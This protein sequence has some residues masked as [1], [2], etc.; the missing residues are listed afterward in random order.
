V[1]LKLLLNDV[2]LVATLEV[3]TSPSN[4]STFIQVDQLLCTTSLPQIAT[5][6]S[7]T[8]LASNDVVG[9]EDR[10]DLI[11]LCGSV[12]DKT[13]RGETK[14]LQCTA[15]IHHELVGTVTASSIVSVNVSGFDD[16]NR[17]TTF[18]QPRS[19]TKK[20]RSETVVLH[21]NAMF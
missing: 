2:L 4:G 21:S 16:C 3:T 9:H 10:L 19:I 18:G 1:K 5:N 20:R 8:D 6:Y 14:L 15:S 7:W 17:P 13:G 12:Q 11:T